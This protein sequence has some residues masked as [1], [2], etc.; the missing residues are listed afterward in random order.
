MGRRSSQLGAVIACL[1]A[2]CLNAQTPPDFRDYR[3]V[4]DVKLVLLDVAVRDSGG[5]FASG[6]RREDFHV[7]DTGKEETIRAFSGEDAPVTVGLLIDHSGSMRTK[8]HEVAKAALTLIRE[9]NR[10]D[11]VFVI[12]FGDR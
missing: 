10:S 9:S 11:E 1:A 5:G 2:L 12:S 8:S 4:S 7:F 6:L 3:I